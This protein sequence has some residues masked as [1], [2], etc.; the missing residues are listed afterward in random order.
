MGEAPGGGL[1]RARA[2]DPVHSVAAEHRGRARPGAQVAGRSVTRARRESRLRC[3]AEGHRAG[4]ALLAHWCVFPA[5]L[6]LWCWL[7]MHDVPA[8]EAQMTVWPEVS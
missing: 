5:A 4:A 1:P 3:C 2:R 7:V 8:V 6:L